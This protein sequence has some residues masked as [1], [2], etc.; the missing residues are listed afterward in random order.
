[1]NMYSTTSWSLCLAVIMVVGSHQLWATEGGDS[2]YELAR[3]AQN[4]VAA[5]ISL[6]LQNNTDFDFGPR[7]KTLN[8]TNIQPVL[9]FELNEN[10]N[11]ITRTV[12]PVISQPG[13]Q[14]GQDRETGIGDTTFTAFLS[15]RNAGSLIWG[16]GPV[17]LLPTNTDDR[18]G[19]DEWGAGPS[20][21][22]LTMPG[23]WVVG[24]LLSNVWDID[25][26]TQINTLTWQYFVNYNF[27]GG[28][29][30][31]S[32]PIMT[33][34]WEAESGEEWTVP[35]GGGFGRIFRIG[36]QPLNASFQYFHNLE[37][38]E[39]TGDWSI[40]AQLQFMFPR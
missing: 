28:W 15:P 21:V 5:M 35:V 11:L 13:L 7:E 37:H 32:S 14:P 34:N 9:P 4:P 27:R 3:A 24:S 1:M 20:V 25:G 17:V 10:W 2:D 26:D 12:M 38:P 39:N 18:L 8:T 36:N 22:V 33:A 40:R 16:A 23:R 6:P 29:Y 19:P 30:L 31:T